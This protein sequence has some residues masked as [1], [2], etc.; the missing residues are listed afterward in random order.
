MTIPPELE[1]FL[2]TIIETVLTNL[3][4]Q[5]GRY[6]EVRWLSRKNKTTDGTVPKSNPEDDHGSEES[7]QASP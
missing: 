7:N 5:F 6:V 2:R 1:I 4:K 3:G